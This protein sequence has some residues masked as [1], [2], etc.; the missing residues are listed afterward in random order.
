MKE[1]V[2][3][4]DFNALWAAHVAQN[5]SPRMKDDQAERNFWQSFMSRKDGYAPDASSR[6]VVQKLLAPLMAEYGIETALEWGP[7]WGNYTID[8]ARHCHKLD[9]VDI[10]PDVLAFI[11][12][13]GGEQGCQ[14]INTIQSKWEDFKPEQKYDLVFGYNCFYRQTNLAR[15]FEK[16]NAAGKKLCIAGMNSGI[17]PVWVSEL[18]STGAQVKWEWKDY[19][20]FVGVLYQMG[21]HA[22]VTVLPFTKELCYPDEDAL[23]RGECARCNSGSIHRDKALEI[24]QHHFIQNT[25]GHWCA[26]AHF[27]SGIVWWTPHA[28]SKIKHSA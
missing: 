1:P 3:F 7:G 19:I 9:C 2:Q 12:R 28:I 25:D 5:D 21:I 20:Y 8:L 4:E 11:R 27:H 13:I 6:Q 22:N 16:M 10:S 14:N 15:C 17:A 18:A 23:F 24:L 26:Q